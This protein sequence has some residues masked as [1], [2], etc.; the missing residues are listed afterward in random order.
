MKTAIWILIF[1]AATTPAVVYF[2]QR[3]RQ[4]V[5][6]REGLAL[7]ATVISVKPI[8]RFGKQL[9]MAKIVMWLQEPDKTTRQVTISSRIEPGQKIEQGVRL[10]IVVDPKNPK[11]IYPAGPEAAK[12]V[13][14]TGSRSERRQMQ[15]GRGVVPSV[16]GRRG[17]R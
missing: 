7:Y 2:Y 8:K 17:A 10:V 6:E 9:P 13:V 5:A 3:W 1:V 14:A 4:T 12:R 16:R 11:R 15:S